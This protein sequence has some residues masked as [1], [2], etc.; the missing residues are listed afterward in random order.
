M[1]KMNKDTIKN[2]E[3][4]KVFIFSRHGIRT[5]VLP[6][7]SRLYKITPHKWKEWDRKSGHLTKKRTLI[8]DALLLQLYEGEKIENIVNGNIDL[9]EKWKRLNEIKDTYIQTL[10][11]N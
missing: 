11:G 6:P 3:L 8:V 10:F 7:E 5:P 9:E 2:F 1:N 4:E